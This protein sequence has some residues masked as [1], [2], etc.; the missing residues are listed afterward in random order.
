MRSNSVMKQRWGIFA[1]T[2]DTD[3]QSLVKVKRI[4]FGNKEHTTDR[5]W[6]RPLY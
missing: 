2:S 1:V 3:S 4:A 5:K 6:E